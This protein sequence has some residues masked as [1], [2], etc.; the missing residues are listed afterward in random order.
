M[1]AT[2]RAMPGCRPETR[3][4]RTMIATIA[5]RPRGRFN[6]GARRPAGLRARGPLPERRRDAAG[7]PG[8]TPLA[9]GAAAGPA[10]PLNEADVNT[11]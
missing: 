7:L 10:A 6:C 1:A 5:E 4:T 3:E 8:R 11:S 2:G 9:G